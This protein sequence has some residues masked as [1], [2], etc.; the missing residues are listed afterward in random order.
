MINFLTILFGII[1]GLIGG[2]GMGGGTLLIPL[3]STLGI[4]QHT[5]QAINLISFLPMSFAAI[6]IHNKNGLLKTTKIGY[7]IISA[8]VASI[9]GASLT[10]L[11]KPEVLKTCFGIF[12]LLFGVYE[13]FSAA[14]AF[15]KKR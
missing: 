1:A 11:I 5:M 4:E 12:L 13:I 15:K 8:L 2:M 7:I 14:F 10:E 6:Y 3:M 9:I